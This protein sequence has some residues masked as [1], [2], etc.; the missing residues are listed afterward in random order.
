MRIRLDIAYVGTRYVGW[1][2]Q[3]NGISV[4]ETVERTLG[5]IYAQPV[6]IVGAGRTDAG[7]HAARQVAHFDAPKNN[8]PSRE[9]Q[10]ILNKLLPGDVGILDVKEVNPSF[11]ARKDATRRTYL[12]RILTSR[13]PDPFRAPCVW[14]APWLSRTSLGKMRRTAK[15][16]LGTKDFAVFAIGAAKKGRTRRTM[17][18]IVIRKVD[19]EIQMTFIADSFLHRMIRRMVAVLADIGAGKSVSKPAFSAPASGLCL[20]NV[21]YR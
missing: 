9:L 21:S 5:Q 13:I 2:R 8:P 17:E 16:W 18:K 6:S 3:P 19:D 1:Q 15:Q 12:Y 20:M 11:H 14:H 10:S 4:Q 7:V